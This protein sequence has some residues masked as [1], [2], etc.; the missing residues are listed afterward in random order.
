[1]PQ[2]ESKGLRKSWWVSG[3]TWFMETRHLQDRKNML[4]MPSSALQTSLIQTRWSIKN[5]CVHCLKLTI[6][7]WKPGCHTFAAGFLRTGA[8]SISSIAPPNAKWSYYSGIQIGGSRKRCHIGITHVH[9]QNLTILIFVFFIVF[10]ILFFTILGT[11][12]MHHHDEVTALLWRYLP[13]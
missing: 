13:W 3:K 10:A 5:H 2:S 9:T 7:L 12:G 4:A 1:M 6:A 11:A 8:S